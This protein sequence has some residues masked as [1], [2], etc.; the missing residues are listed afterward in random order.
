MLGLQRATIRGPF[1]R[2]PTGLLHT[3][4]NHDAA[5]TADTALSE[6]SPSSFQVD[7]IHRREGSAGREVIVQGGTRLSKTPVDGAAFFDL[8][9]QLAASLLHVGRVIV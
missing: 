7:R 6:Q 5:M 2:T 1:Y 8:G 4:K 9:W 3:H